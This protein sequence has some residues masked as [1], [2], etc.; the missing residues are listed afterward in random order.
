MQS[1]P[2]P[3]NSDS[4][5]RKIDEQINHINPNTVILRFIDQRD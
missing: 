4:N 5:I 1:R 2:E 3:D